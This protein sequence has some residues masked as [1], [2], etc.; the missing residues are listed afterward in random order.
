MQKKSAILALCLLFSGLL[1]FGQV[2]NGTI[3]GTVTDASGAVVSGATVQAK[4]TA[5]GVAFSAATSNAGAYTITDLPVGTYSVAVAVKGFKA[6]THTNLALEATQILREDIKLQIGDTAESVTVTAE[7][8]LLATETGEMAHNVNIQQLDELP[9]LG[10]GTANAGTQGIRNPFNALQALPGVSSYSAGNQFTLNGLGGTTTPEAMRIEGQDATPHDLGSIYTNMAQPSTD[11]IQEVAYQTSNYAPEYGTVGAVLI[12][13]T[14][15]SGTNQYHGSGYE[16]LVNEDLNAGDPY[17]ISGGPGSLAGGDKGKYRP[18]SRRDNFGGTLGGPVYIPKIYNGHNKTFFFFNYEQYLE[19]TTLSFTDTVPAAAY[20]QGN[21]SAISPNGNCSL[22]STYGIPT[23]ALGGNQVDPLGNQ[24]FANEIYDPQ[25]R[26][27]ATSGPLAGQGYATPFPNNSIPLTRFDPVAIKLQALFQ[28]LGAVAQTSSLTGNYTGT[29]PSHRYSVV[30]SFKID[31]NIDSKDKLS[32]YYQETNT[33]SQVSTP[34]GNADGLPLEIGAYRGTFVPT[35][36]YRLNYDR[37]LTPTLLL[38]IGAGYYYNTFSDHAAYLDFNPSSLGLT[39]FIQDRQF[40]SFTGMS[41]TAYGGMQNVGTL[42]QIQSLTRESKPSFNVNVTNVRGKH[43]YKLGAEVYYQGIF[44]HPYSGVSFP[45]GTGPTSEPFT[46]ANSLGGF[47]EGF[48]YA[49]FLLG[50]YTG[51]TQNAIEAYRVG[52]AQYAMYIQDSWKVTRKLTVDYG[53]RWDLATTPRETYGRLGQIDPTLANPNAGGHP[54]AVQY[55]STCGCTFYE[56]SYPY[57]IGP[58]IGVAYQ[59]D[60]KTVIRGGWGVLY[61]FVFGSA[62]SAVSTNGVY[63]VAANSPSYVPT[64]YQYVNIETPGAIVQPAWPVTNPYI[65]PNPGTTAPAPTV[66]DVNQNRPPRINQFSV[67]IQREIT[68]NFIMEATYVGN[69]AAWVQQGGGPLGYLSQISPAQYAKYGLYPYPG[70]GPAGYNNNNDRVLLADP[71]SSTAVI[72][73]MDARGITN[74]LPYS[75]FPTSSTLASTLVPFPQFGAVEPTGSPTGDSKYDSL[76]MKA[77]KRLS[78][79]L[80]AGGTFTWAQGFTRATRQDFFNPASAV[81]ALQQIPPRDL[82]FNF[83]YTTPKA[84]FLPKY[85]NAI[86]KDWQVGGFANYQSGAF[87]TPPISPTANF[88]P[89]EDIR[90]AGQP[91]YNVNINDIHSYNPYYQQ[92]LNPNAWTACPTNATCAAAAS[93]TTGTVFYKDFRAPRTPEE[94]ASFGRNFRIKERM[95]LQIR[96]EFVNIFNRTLLPSPI[97]TNPQNLPAKNAL[98]IYTSGFGIIN[99]YLTPN[100]A[101]ALPSQSAAFYLQPRTGTIIARFSF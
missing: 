71:I 10:V 101:Y 84:S 66:P 12:N 47:S 20:T 93:A 37:T 67:G 18:R 74:L 61:D 86:I 91:L 7:A 65:Y 34:N 54:G 43:T 51:T 94:N 52:Y 6:Y 41:S 38:H 5:T 90:V 27:Q 88:L 13:M 89:S 72:Q 55:A 44:H 59:V 28:S 17:S 26:G 31:H 45:T 14:M 15:R 69:R 57:A 96:G 87:L 63:P 30:P 22:C 56:P 50:D 95:N 11:A 33:Q 70:T 97:T 81:W 92:V 76:Q 46:P 48:G 83:T 24:I 40:P 21:F 82:N 29:V 35:Y 64:A 98:G 79:G 3:T 85:A 25:T 42:G 19:T 8:S 68:R 75:G 77:T 1:A 49:S 78:H 99:T 80:T 32:F 23:T 62:G 16:Y 73:A 58:R 60:P 36:I 100:T 2:G 4:N 53:L 9:L 39:G